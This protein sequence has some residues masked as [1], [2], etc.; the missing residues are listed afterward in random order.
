M[1]KWFKR[2]AIGLVVLIIALQ[3]YP[4]DRSNP[5]ER[6]EPPGPPE[7]KALLRRSCFDCHS[8]ET[9]WPWYAR[10]APVSLL[11]ARDVQNGRKEV[12]FSTW[13][14]LDEKRKARKLKDIA[15]EVGDGDMPLFYYL[16]LHPDAKLSAAERE[17]IVKWAKQS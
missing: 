8:N 15:K 16:P 9:I 7:V 3:F 14:K 2:I 10:F 17:L 5:S 11:I 4:I 6:S 12:N 13:E 1:K